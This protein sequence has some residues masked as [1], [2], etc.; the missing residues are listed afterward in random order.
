MTCSKGNKGSLGQN[1][2]VLTP[3]GRPVDLLEPDLD[4]ALESLYRMEWVGITDL[5][6]PSLCLLHFQANQ[7][8]PRA[9]DCLNPEHH[10]N[11]PGKKP[12]G[13]WDEYRNKPIKSE[14]LSPRTSQM[15]DAHTTVD[16][17]LFSAALRLF[18]GR[19]RRLE[20]LTGVSVLE[21]VDWVDF[22]RKTDYIPGLWTGEQ[23]SLL[24]SEDVGE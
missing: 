9:C 11:D 24:L 1:F 7:T 18:L 8:L 16:V 14:N 15:V 3:Q 6:H 19:L 10:T 23:D 21:C 17:K 20:E 2:R 5:F 12:L 13:Y 22:R 4:E